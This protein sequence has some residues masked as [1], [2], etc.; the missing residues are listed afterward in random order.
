[1]TALVND[2]GRT[3]SSPCTVTVFGR[4]CDEQNYRSWRRLAV[5]MRRALL[6]G[7]WSKPGT[8]N[9]HV[10]MVAW[11]KLWIDTSEADGPAEL[12]IELGRTLKLA[13]PE[14]TNTG[15]FPADLAW[16]EGGYSP[17]GVIY[18][19]KTLALVHYLKQGKQ[20]YEDAIKLGVITKED[21][22]I[23]DPPASPTQWLPVVGYALA[24]GGVIGFIVWAYSTIVRARQSRDDA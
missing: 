1:M 24:T 15:R 3:L 4:T 2:M 8:G 13:D 21:K 12:A 22:R 17:G 7:N 20:V 5:L 14:V 10:E 16:Y 23:S 6:E 19:D 11:L 18:N 9:V